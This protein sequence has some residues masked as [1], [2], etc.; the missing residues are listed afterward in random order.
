MRRMRQAGPWM[1]A[2][3]TLVGFACADEP[4]EPRAPELRARIEPD[5][6][7][8]CADPDPAPTYPGYFLGTGVTPYKCTQGGHNDLD[9]DGFSDFCEN[10]IGTAFAPQLYYW[11]GDYVDR[12]PRWALR[13]LTPG[14]DKVR[15]AYLFSYYRDEGPVIWCPLGGEICNGH[16][17]DSEMIVVD[18]RYVGGVKQ[19]WVTDSAF[20][21]Q[22]EWMG[23]VK[24]LPGDIYPT[25]IYVATLVWDGGSFVIENIPWDP[26]LEA[27]YPD[28]PGGYL[29]VFVSQGKHAS[30]FHAEECRHAAHGYDRCESLN[31]LARLAVD[32]NNNLGSGWSPFTDC[33][34]AAS[35][36]HPYY[37]SEREECYWQEVPFR[38]WFPES[39]GGGQAGAYAAKLAA[40]GFELYP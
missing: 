5:C 7:E 16:N 37:G 19:H 13:S 21:M 12:E 20:F 36:A 34:G 30:F 38:G 14:G 28:R 35:P 26:P 10:W 8:G 15:I 18:L 1:M 33:V 11:N 25:D 17:G 3:L 23:Y 9:N 39:I 27:T 4:T 32:W 2:V 6:M 29:R 24:R 40:W 31:S 22:H